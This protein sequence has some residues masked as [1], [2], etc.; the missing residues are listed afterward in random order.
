M[1][2]D[3]QYNASYLL[4]HTERD[5]K[6]FSCF[7]ALT[8]LENSAAHSVYHIMTDSIYLSVLYKTVLLCSANAFHSKTVK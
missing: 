6:M 3:A 7:P 2:R 1:C 8:I 4:I 5:I